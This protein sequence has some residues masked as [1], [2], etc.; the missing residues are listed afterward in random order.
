[1]NQQLELSVLIATHNRRELLRRC[2]D[3]LSRQTQDPATFEVIVAD[4]GSSD[5]TA[6]MAEGFEAPFRLR[7][8]RLEK[9]GRAHA[10]NAA[11]AVAEGARCLFLD[12]DMIASPELVEGHVEAHRSDPQS[13]GVGAI[14]QQPPEGRDWYAHTHAKSWNAHFEEFANREPHWTD[15]YGANLSLP[16]EVLVDLGGV[17]TDVLTGED[18]DLACRLYDSGC[19][20]TYLPNAHGVHDDQKR[21]RRMLGDARLQGAAHLEL[22]ASLPG[23]RELPARLVRAG[24]T[25][26]DRPAP[27]PHRPAR[28]ADAA[29]P[30]GTLHPRLRSRA[31]LVLVRPQVRLLAWGTGARQPRR[32]DAAH[33]RRH[34]GGLPGDSAIAD[35]VPERPHRAAAVNDPPE[36]ELSVLIASHNRRD[37]LR[38][39]LESLSRQTQDPATFEVIVAD[40]GSSDGTAEMAEAFEAPY[41]LAVLR[42]EKSSH[43]AAQN[44]AIEL[45]T[46]PRC[47]LLDDDMIASPEL[48]AEHVAAHRRDPTCIGVGTITQQPPKGRDWYARTHAKSWNL[49]Y[50]EFDRRPAHWTDCYGANLSVPRE[51]LVDNGGISVE[52]PTGKDLDLGFRLSQAGC[53]PTY[54][55]GAHGIHDDQKRRRRMLQDAERQGAM[56]LE[57]SHRHP[58]RAPD[59]LDWDGREGPRSS[60]CAAC[61]SPSG[62]RPRRWR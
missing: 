61:S 31:A 21:C 25:Q 59:L 16:R 39:C 51:A 2:L 12:D 40:D 19:R 3:S 18:L 45:T 50:E 62:S 46:A 6:E 55:P 23:A 14:T 58:E 10:H 47:L 44:A 20:P 33:R 15:C 22:L 30:H 9:E 52:V 4:D 36:A 35:V 1:M 17:A 11:I 29:R 34:R 57:L 49:H 37:L 26:G 5:G 28:A 48:V 24:G 27:P 8:L 54:L 41:S 43:A 7:V 32:M 56:H 53:T 42:L 38:R 13:V 60:S